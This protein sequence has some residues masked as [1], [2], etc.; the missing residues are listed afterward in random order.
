MSKPL[1]PKQRAFV[2][3]WI[4]N[5]GNGMPPFGS[6]MTPQEVQQVVDFIVGLGTG[7]PPSQ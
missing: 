5:G 2:A 1:T 4:E 6:R 3:A 7:T